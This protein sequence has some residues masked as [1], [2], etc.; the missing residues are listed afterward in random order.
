MILAKAVLE[1]CPGLNAFTCPFIGFPTKDKSLV[2]GGGEQHT[3]KYK[4]TEQFKFK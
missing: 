2:K 3:F 1:K 4:R